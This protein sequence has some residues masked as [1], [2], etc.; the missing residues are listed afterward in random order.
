MELDEIEKTC[1]IDKCKYKVLE[2]GYCIKHQKFY[3]MNESLK[4]NLDKVVCSF[5]KRGCTNLVDKNAKFTRCDSCREKERLRDNK[6]RHAEKELTDQ[7]NMIC[8]SCKQEYP[9]ENFIGIKNN[10]TKTCAKCREQNY[11]QDQKRVKKN[12]PYS[13]LKKDPIRYARK[14]ETS[15]LWRQNNPG[16]DKKY[17]KQKIEK[18][19]ID[20]FHRHNANIAKEWRDKN[21]E[22]VKISNIKRLNNDKIYYTVYKFRANKCDIPFELSRDEYY[23]MIK[24][25]CH[26]C[27]CVS[28][29]RSGV[30]RKDNDRGYCLDNCVPCCTMCNFIKNTYSVKDFLIF[31]D[32]IIIQNGLNHDEYI[33]HGIKLSDLKNDPLVGLTIKNI[34][35]DYDSVSY[36]AYKIRANKKNLPF[37]LSK[38]QFNEIKKLDCYICGKPTII[39]HNNGIDRF[40]NNK[41]YVKD[42]V[43][44]CCGQC[45][46]MKR[47]YDYYEFME[48]LYTI[49]CHNHNL[50]KLFTI[51]D[52]KLILNVEQKIAATSDVIDH[53]D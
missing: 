11:K 3:I 27:N 30:D 12:K 20:E 45:N 43:V 29:I 16:I 21:P 18:I 33:Y 50:H 25:P 15:K 26:Y 52:I 7:N 53:I 17:R 9:K 6:Y 32:Y 13:E 10:I 37:E 24:Q 8:N 41:G 40:D 19:G 22:H 28:K 4:N 31:V 39:G 14:Q 46:R 1:A 38:N 42:N 36:I 5:F 44:P 48:K 35:K 34:L 49:Y 23:G 2:N 51:Q 47:N